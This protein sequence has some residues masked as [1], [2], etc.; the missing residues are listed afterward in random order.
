M[1]FSKNWG[2]VAQAKRAFQVEVI[3]PVFGPT[4]DVIFPGL[5]RTEKG[6]ASQVVYSDGDRWQA[7]GDNKSRPPLH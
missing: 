1:F 2:I 5:A 3:H 7:V 6:Q 4:G